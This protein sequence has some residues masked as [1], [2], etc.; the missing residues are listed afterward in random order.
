MEET[1]N[2]MAGQ[3]RSSVPLT[4][5]DSSVSGRVLQVA[6]CHQLHS[7]S[8]DT[9]AETVERPE[10]AE[11]FETPATDAVFAPSPTIKLHELDSASDDIEITRLPWGYAVTR[12]TRTP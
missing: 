12:K 9:A 11:C 7:S 3:S 4:L 2:A 1:S 8:D 6:D 5:D 10:N